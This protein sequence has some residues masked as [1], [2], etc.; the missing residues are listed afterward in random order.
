L[1]IVDYGQQGSKIT[2]LN[3]EE[4]C[5]GRTAED[6][7]HLLAFHHDRVGKPI[8]IHRKMRT[9]LETHLR[10]MYPASFAQDKWLGDM[11]KRIREEGPTNPAHHLYDDLN[12]INDSAVFHHGEDLSTN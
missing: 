10:T 11:I 3:L 8:D 7:D 9:V 4:C 1:G 6:I 5:K 12:E 2:A